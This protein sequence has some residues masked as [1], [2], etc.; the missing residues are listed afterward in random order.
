MNWIKSLFLKL[1]YKIDNLPA[2]L[3]FAIEKSEYG[4]FS[5]TAFLGLPQI[6]S[7][8]KKV[9]LYDNV[10]IWEGAKF[11]ISPVSSSGRFIVKKGSRCAQNLTVITGNHIKKYPLDTLR[12]INHINRSGDID[13]DII[14]E[15]EAWIGINVTLL[16][17]AK[18]GRG[19]IIGAGSVIRKSVPPYSIVIGDPARVISF[20]FT[21]EEIVEHELLCYSESERYDYNILKDNYTK[22]YINKIKDPNIKL[23]V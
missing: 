9:F 8:P 20:V 13:L 21:P 4:Y 5:K 1:L 22:F 14:I 23:Y 19:A 12:H 6:S 3:I 18:I 15:E 16:A 11:I 2:K 17:G 10:N 7:C